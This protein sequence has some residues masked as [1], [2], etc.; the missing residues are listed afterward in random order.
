MSEI[1]VNTIKKAD[2]TGS[3]TVP[4]D[5]GTLLTSASDVVANSGPA[6]GAYTATSTESI[7]SDTWTKV[8]LSTEEFD[9]NSNFASSR[10]TP[11]VEGYYQLNWAAYLEAGS[12][13]TRV[14]SQLYKNGSLYKL[15]SYTGPVTADNLRGVSTGSSLVYMNGSTD[16][17]E[18]YVY[19]TASTSPGIAHAQNQTYLNGYLARTV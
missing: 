7:S 12:T 2:G 8:T 19:I 4:A 5:S 15:G 16:Y 13:I 9:T 14:I 10:F 6:F 3:I 11:T 17:V 18:L 1:L